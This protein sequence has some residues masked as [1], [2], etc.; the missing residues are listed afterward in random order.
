[1]QKIWQKAGIIWLA[2]MVSLGILIVIG[3]LT[4]QVTMH[5]ARVEDSLSATNTLLYLQNPTAEL[6][7]AMQRVYPSLDLDLNDVPNNALALFYVRTDAQ[8]MKGYVLHLEDNPL[9]QKAAFTDRGLGFFIIG[10][11]NTS[12]TRATDRPL[13]QLPAYN[14]FI[15]L[16]KPA[17]NFAYI[18]AD[19]LPNSTGPI[20]LSTEANVI[21]IDTIEP[22]TIMEDTPMQVPAMLHNSTTVFTSNPQFLLQTWRQATSSTEETLALSHMQTWWNQNVETSKSINYQILPA[23][24]KQVSLELSTISGSTI[25]AA[26][27]VRTAAIDAL[28][29]EITTPKNNIVPVIID[30]NLG[31]FTQKNIRAGQTVTTDEINQFTI[32]D[33]NIRTMHSEANPL[34][35]GTTNTHWFLSNQALP[36]LTKSLTESNATSTE[37]RSIVPEQSIAYGSGT[38]LFPMP[39][40]K[41]S[42]INQWRMLQIGTIRRLELEIAK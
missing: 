21:T 11:S 30:R 10:T 26:Q 9:E 15:N 7:E 42:T 24:Q 35:I 8:P 5:S 33:W 36:A 22:Q 23:V 37:L 1:M 32:G 20:T 27:G 39:E 31:D 41:N 28:I 14:E 29:D 25:V 18:H 34:F 2:C 38:A 4:Y 12:L 40:F 6:V 13:S 17:A 3:I 19:A 16:Q